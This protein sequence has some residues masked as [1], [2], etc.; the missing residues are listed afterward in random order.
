MAT[1]HLS[2]AAHLLLY[3]DLF[4]MCVSWMA[5]S[6]KEGVETRNALLKL[7]IIAALNDSYGQIENNAE[8]SE[9]KEDKENLRKLRPKKR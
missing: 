9:I 4:E 1:T 6:V 8:A 7:Q 2:Y 3:Q 5:N